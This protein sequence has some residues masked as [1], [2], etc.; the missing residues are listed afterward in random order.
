MGFWKSDKRS[1]CHLLMNK[2][3]SSEIHVG[4]SISEVVIM[5][6]YWALKSIQNLIFDDHVQDPCKKSIKKLR[7]LAWAT[8][9]LIPFWHTI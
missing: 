8:L 9:H 7:A 2:D 1:K 6:N 4:E 3:K 5:K